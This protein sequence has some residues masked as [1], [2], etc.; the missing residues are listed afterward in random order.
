M[1]ESEWPKYLVGVSKE[2]IYAV[3][4][5]IANWAD[6]ESQIY[7]IMHHLMKSPETSHMMF[8]NMHN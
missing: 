7:G 3:G 6:V 2:H 4:V 8:H 5:L 1:S